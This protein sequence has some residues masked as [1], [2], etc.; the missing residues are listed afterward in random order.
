MRKLNLVLENI[1]DEYMINFLEENT[2]SELEILKTKKFLNESLL[3]MRKFLIEEG[4]L[5]GIKQHLANNWGKYLAG[6]GA[7][8]AAGL[9]A[10]AY[11]NGWGPFGIDRSGQDELT[12]FEGKPVKPEDMTSPEEQAAWNQ[13]HLDEL[14]HAEKMAKLQGSQ[15]AEYKDVPAPYEDKNTGI[16]NGPGNG[17]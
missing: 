9:G 16:Y 3:E 10:A 6:A 4:N 12:D 17:R 13:K 14:N 11:H 1:R 2:A 7:L 5:D 15:P 8:G